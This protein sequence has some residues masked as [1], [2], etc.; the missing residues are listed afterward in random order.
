MQSDSPQHQYQEEE[1]LG[2]F[3]EA[4]EATEKTPEVPEDVEMESQSDD[5]DYNER[6]IAEDPSSPSKVF[7][8]V[9]CLRRE[10]ANFASQFPQ[11][12]DDDENSLLAGAHSVESRLHRKISHHQNVNK[13]NVVMQKMKQQIQ[14][15]WAELDDK[16]ND[17]IEEIMDIND[18]EAELEELEKEL[19][20]MERGRAAIVKDPQQFKDACVFCNSDTHASKNCGQYDEAETRKKRLQMVGRCDSCLEKVD[21]TGKT[22][23]KI[24]T[25]FTKEC[26]HCK[27]GFHSPAIC[28]IFS[29]KQRVAA[30][31]QTQKAAFDILYRKWKEENEEKKESPAKKK[32]E[33][34]GSRGRE[35]IS[36]IP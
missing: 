6:R 24:G 28:T 1:L 8:K 12:L 9:V 27:N 15:I 30:R 3:S 20:S 14:D 32:E 17:V 34:G 29:S 2:G 33:S 13:I 35:K 21:H 16:T 26:Q 23:D 11:L 10:D 18:D 4:E 25:T 36:Y 19:E 22:C 5:D 7:N 31:I